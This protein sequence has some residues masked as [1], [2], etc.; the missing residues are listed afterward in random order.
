MRFVNGAIALV[1]LCAH[2]SNALLEEKFVSF[3]PGNKPLD[4]A[5]ATIIADA[6]DFVGVH[7]AIKSL[8]DDL[9]QITGVKS[10]IRNITANSTISANS[11]SAPAYGKAIIVAS[12]NSSLVQ[13]LSGRNG[14]DFSELGGKWET[15]KTLVATNPL[16]GINQALVIVG[17]D[18]RGTVFGVHTLAEQSGQSP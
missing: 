5:G 18:K 10:E 7:I 13:Q 9:K 2:L 3:T 16:P 6:N 8:A 11:T 4:I 15:F 12:L 1:A 17:S 14:I